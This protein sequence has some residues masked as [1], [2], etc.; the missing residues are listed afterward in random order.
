MLV[1][2]KNVLRD[3]DPVSDDEPVL[4]AV[5]GEGRLAESALQVNHYLRKP[6]LNLYQFPDASE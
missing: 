4:Q 1:L 2:E 5:V 3:D 6:T